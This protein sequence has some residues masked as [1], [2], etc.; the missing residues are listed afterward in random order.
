MN[1]AFERVLIS[2]EEIAADIARVAA[3]ISRDYEGKNPLFVCILKGSIFFFADLLRAVTIPAELDFM[4]ISSY[5]SS[6]VSSGEVK[7]IKDLD[8]CIEGRHVIV[9]EDI[10]D[11]GNTHA[12]L[13]ALLKTRKP[14]SVEVCTLL[15]K[16]ERRQTEVDVKYKGRNIPDEFVVGYGL[17]YAEKYR[18]T[19][20]IY[21]LSRSIYE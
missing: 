5:G 8:R 7:M 12:Y 1:E 14:A 17:D 18:N 16:P 9:V 15:D 13:T 21:V 6:S 4:S 19:S 10:L 11:T 3:E 2:K 20:D